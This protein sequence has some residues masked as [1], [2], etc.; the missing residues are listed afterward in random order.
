MR[1]R[2]GTNPRHRAMSPSS[3]RSCARA[4]GVS[5]PEPLAAARQRCRADLAWLPPTAR[6]LRDPGTGTGP[7]Q[8]PPQGPA[9]PG[10]PRP[11]TARWFSG[12]SRGQMTA[13]ARIT[14]LFSCCPCRATWPP[15]PSCCTVS[16]PGRGQTRGRARP[17]P[18]ISVPAWRRCRRHPRPPR[19]MSGRRP[20]PVGSR[21]RAG[22][23]GSEAGGPGWAYLPRPRSGGQTILTAEAGHEA[24]SCPPRVSRPVI[25]SRRPGDGSIIS[26]GW[27]CGPRSL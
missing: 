16:A 14:G 23:P 4:G 6:A 10:N 9:G 25:V 27:S 12:L 8:R 21:R 19:R 26:P 24:L 11:Q 5:A 3:S 17:Q 20:A 15:S 2:Y 7:D 1:P 22:A 18:G 13:S